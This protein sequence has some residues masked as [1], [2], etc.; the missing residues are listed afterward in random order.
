MSI[1]LG[2][3]GEALSLIW[4]LLT[5]VWGFLIDHLAEIKEAARWILQT[6][7]NMLG[8]S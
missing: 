3:L 8:G 4:A 7:S 5:R 1:P 6:L 2:A